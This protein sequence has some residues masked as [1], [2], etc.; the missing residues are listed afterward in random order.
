MRIIRKLSFFGILAVAI[1]VLFLVGISFVQ[2]QSKTP[3]GKP[4]KPPGKPDKPGEEKVTWAVQL[5][6]FGGSGMLYGDGLRDYSSQEE[7]IE[8]KVEYNKM[9]GTWGK[10]NDFVTH[11]S[12][13]LSNSTSN[14]HYVGFE[15]VPAFSNINPNDYD[16]VDPDY[17]K[18]CCVFPQQTNDVLCNECRFSTC[19]N[20]FMVGRVHPDTDYAFFLID[21]RAFD[22][23][24][25][26]MDFG[27]L[28]RYQLGQ[29]GHEHDYINMKINYQRSDI[30]TEPTYHNILCSKSAHRGMEGRPFN[31]WI[32]RIDENTWKID[33]GSPEDDTFFFFVE[34]YY[35]EKTEGRK[36]KSKTEFYSTLYQGGEFYFTFNLIKE[37]PQ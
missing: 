5:P 30:Y 26:N 35:Y 23:D 18:P 3:K 34:E 20:E 4:V 1:A 28:Y 31:I 10:D 15:G 14:Y 17:G 12:F 22:K 21:I 29:P 16:Y 8:V 11:I 2:A 24:I 37:T 9:S 6:S 36:G 33:V 19:M 13:K 25:L 27:E 7:N 32:E